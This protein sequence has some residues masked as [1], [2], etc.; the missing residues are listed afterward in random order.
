MTLVCAASLY[1]TKSCE[2]LFSSLP[3]LF[4]KIRPCA[5][6]ISPSQEPDSI[7]LVWSLSVLPR[8][9]VRRTFCAHAAKPLKYHIVGIISII[10]GPIDAADRGS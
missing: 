9:R 1:W 5:A 7:R 3:H 10:Q 8:D 4:L 6:S 2:G